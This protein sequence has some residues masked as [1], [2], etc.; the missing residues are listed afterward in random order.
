M[1]KQTN[2]TVDSENIKLMD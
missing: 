1:N 2:G